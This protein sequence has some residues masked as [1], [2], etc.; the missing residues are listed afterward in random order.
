MCIK[1]YCFLRGTVLA[2]MDTVIL[3]QTKFHYCHLLLWLIT[4]C[5][6]NKNQP[7]FAFCVLS[8]F[9][10]LTLK[11]QWFLHPPPGLT[12]SKSMFCPHSVFMRCEWNSE[13]TAIVSLCSI[14][15]MIYITMLKCVYCEVQ[16][17]YLCIMQ[18]NLS[19]WRFKCKYDWPSI[20][21]S[22]AESR[23]KVRLS[24]K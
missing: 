18:A 17:E 8:Y 10:L 14:N 19:L 4:T 12:V 22:W 21:S 5:Y 2:K 3:T 11:F 7:F 24:C 15:W 13:Q 6:N 23:V 1:W 20:K 16:T 9:I